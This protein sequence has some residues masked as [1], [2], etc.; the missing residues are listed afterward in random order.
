MKRWL[1]PKLQARLDEMERRL[2]APTPRAPRGQAPRQRSRNVTSA[3]LAEPDAY[4]EVTQ[5]IQEYIRAGDCYQVVP[6]R[7]SRDGHTAHPFAVY[8][9]LR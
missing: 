6:S 9:A 1:A 3:P 4:M 2:R 8:R 7:R 5:R